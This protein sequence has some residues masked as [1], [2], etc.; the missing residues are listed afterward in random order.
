MSDL[1]KPFVVPVSLG[2]LVGLFL[3]Q[4]RGTARV[5]AIFGPAIV[6]WFL[7]IAALGLPWIVRHPEVLAAL[8]P[9]HGARFLFGHGLHGLFVLGAVVLCFTGTE[10]LYADM[11]HFGA[12]PIR[13]A[14]SVMV[15]PC[16]LLNYFGQGAA[17]LGGDPRIV[18]NPFF[19]LAP[20]APLYP[21]VVVATVAAVIASQALI[22]G[23]FS[24]AQQAMQL[25]YSPRLDIVHTSPAA[26][27]QI[28][29]PQVNHLLL[30][31]CCLLTL[32]FRS[33]SNL[34]A[35]YGLAVTGTM[36]VTSVL[37]FA[38]ARERWGWG[39]S[40]AG[41]LVALFLCLDLPFF[42]ANAVKLL[43]GGWLPLV[44]GAAVFT[45]FV[46][47]KTGRELLAEE[48]R[49]GLVTLEQFLP[50][51]KHEK[52]HRV[53]GTAVFMTSNLEF[54]PPVLL[55]NFKHN[56]IL[57]Q[58]VILLYVVIEHVPA[59]PLE[60][61]VTVRD[62]GDGLYAVVARFGFMERPDVPRALKRCRSQGLRVKPGETSYYLG[63]ETLLTTGT[64]PM[65]R[66]RKALFAYLSRNARPATAFF[67]LPPN[68][69]LELGMQVQL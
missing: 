2:I 53:S 29:V 46:T 10:A 47:W 34:A 42:A 54:V 40:A 38:V 11:G 22:S 3:V 33:S 52:P 8:S 56:K 51:L 55:H 13:F 12:R 15:F 14:W 30:V 17:I 44:V 25:G 24:L 37:L 31:A 26:R 58:Q 19:A 4:K 43:H 49:R 41:T 61:R 6:L 35:A 50:S 9:W 18:A 60:E 45:I 21:V 48:T 68:R 16:L 28:Y 23:S 67:S 27:G 64:S 69:V 20:Q 36:I 66:W 57:H 65:S 39:R 32:V 62:F 7:M 59:V 63:R 1:F 5:G